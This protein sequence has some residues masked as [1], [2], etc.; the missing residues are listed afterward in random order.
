MQY[1]VAKD[2]VASFMHLRKVH[3][4]L[5]DAQWLLKRLAGKL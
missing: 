3:A 4:V 2:A 1:A 5:L